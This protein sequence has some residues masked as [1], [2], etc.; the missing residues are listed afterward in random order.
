MPAA[1]IPITQGQSAPTFMPPKNWGF[2]EASYTFQATKL[3]TSDRCVELTRR[4]NY[5]DCTHHDYKKYDFDG[6]YI[7]PGPW[8]MQ[9]PLMSNSAAPFYVPLS[10]RKPSAPLRLGKQIVVAFTNLAFGEDRWPDLLCKGD[11]TTQDFV[12]ALAEAA[13]LPVKMV[14]GRNKSGSQGAVGMSWYFHNG[15]PI[16]EV[17]PVQFL[18][19]H[20]WADLAKWKPNHVTKCYKH[21]RSVW[22]PETK[23]VTDKEFWYRRDWTPLADIFY[24]EVEAKSN[25]EPAWEIDEKRSVVHGDGFCHFVWWQNVPCSDNPDGKPDYNGLYEKL[26]EVD[27]INSVVCR[28]GKL[29]LDPTLKLKMEPEAV[30]GCMVKKGSDNALV[31]GEGGDAAYLEL[32]GTSLEAGGKLVDRLTKQVLDEAECVITNPDEVAAGSVSSVALQIVYAPML[33]RLSLVKATA[34]ATIVELLTQ[35]L[36]VARARW[37]ET[38]KV[39]DEAGNETGEERAVTNYLNLPPKVVEEEVKDPATGKPTGE[40][41][42][43]FEEREP[44]QGERVELAWG[45][46]FKPNSVDVQNVVTTMSTATGGKAVVS[47]K[48][49]VEVVAN[50][51]G[52]DPKTVLEELEH[53]NQTQMQMNGTMFGMPGAGDTMTADEAAQQAAGG[54]APG[55]EPAE[56]DPEVELAK[57]AEREAAEHGLGNEQA[58]Q[59]AQDH[60]DMDPA[61]YSKEDAGAQQAA[62]GK[63]GAP[64]EVKAP[65]RPKIALTSTDL[66]AIITVNEAR[67]QYGFGPWPDADGELSLAEFKVKH[68]KEVS[69]SAQADKGQDPNKP[70]PAPPAAFGGA[71][72][73][74]PPFGKKA[75]PGAPGA[76][77]PGDGEEPKP[78]KKPPFGK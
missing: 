18:H 73:G 5:F 52:K 12:Q 38:E 26:D 15:D 2:S 29:N 54:A 30:G 60:L 24:K 37:S 51:L 1:V 72:G 11:E 28:G 8:T 71:P 47:Q 16:V 68:G 10:Q 64:V 25:V 6:R 41:S 48:T 40:V 39:R 55:G 61:Y 19:V 45:P 27:T 33:A 44:G 43:T 75:P 53:D 46:T 67:A 13:Q 49:A 35:M 69:G 4:G 22:D 23:A 9:Q 17:H 63:P 36:T 74:K 70:P 62:G 21:T 76:P 59:I 32:S 65:E 66:G 7:K 34:G 77:Q 20:E 58:R 78:E 50:L 42:I 56:L 57:G 14:E 3:V 31:T